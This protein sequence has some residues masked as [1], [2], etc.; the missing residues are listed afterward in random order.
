MRDC[1]RKEEKASLSLVAAVSD[2][3]YYCCGHYTQCE[4]YETLKLLILI[5]HICVLLET[6]RQM[7]VQPRYLGLLICPI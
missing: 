5:Y 7:D 1:K 3:N 4:A 6:Y 2:A